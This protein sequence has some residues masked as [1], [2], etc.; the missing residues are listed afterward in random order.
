MIEVYGFFI[1]LLVATTF[2]FSMS[3]GK[4]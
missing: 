3:D 4:V 1:A 2:C